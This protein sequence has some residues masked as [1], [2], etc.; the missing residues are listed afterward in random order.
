MAYTPTVWETG[1][2]ITAEKLNKAE[3]GI[4]AASGIVGVF[5]IGVTHEGNVATLNKKYSDSL[6]AVSAGQLG[7][8]YEIVE[9]EYSGDYIV[10]M[11]LDS[12]SYTVATNQDAVF[13]TDSEDGYPSKTVE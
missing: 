1:D 12:D 6:A 8:I 13:T 11:Y 2:V 4:A 10:S 7:I 3:Q 9:G 5:P